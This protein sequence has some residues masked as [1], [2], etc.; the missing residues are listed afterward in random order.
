MNRN[1]PT[2]RE[3]EAKHNTLGS[4]SGDAYLRTPTDADHGPDALISLITDLCQ[5]IAAIEG[6][7]NHVFILAYGTNLIAEEEEDG[8]R[9]SMGNIND[10][11]DLIVRTG[12]R[13][14]SV[15]HFITRVHKDINND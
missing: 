4:G 9:V 8:P 12:G 6:R 10:T 2:R 7:V 13:L 15:E 3:A 14:D 1:T 11:K 5:R